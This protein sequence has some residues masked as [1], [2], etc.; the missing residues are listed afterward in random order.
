MRSQTINPQS[1]L[2]SFISSISHNCEVYKTG[3]YLHL[4]DDS[5]KQHMKCCFLIDQ[6]RSEL[7]INKAC[8]LRETWIS[9]EMSCCMPIQ[10]ANWTRAWAISEMNQKAHV[11]VRLEINLTLVLKKGL[12][13][14]INPWLICWFLLSSVLHSSYSKSQNTFI[15]KEVFW[16]WLIDES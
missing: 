2:H 15:S 4:S 8:I 14:T 7:S 13:F 5:Y 9:T 11:L 6:W 12:L 16:T 1:Q 10:L 3:K